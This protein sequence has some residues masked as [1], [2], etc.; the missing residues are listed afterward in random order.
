MAVR[1]ELNT[2]LVGERSY[3]GMKPG[4]LLIYL[5]RPTNL[6]PQIPIALGDRYPCFKLGR[7]ISITNAPQLTIFIQI[8]MTLSASK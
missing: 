1:F 6:F 3:V 8:L 7:S 4:M 2:H 5:I